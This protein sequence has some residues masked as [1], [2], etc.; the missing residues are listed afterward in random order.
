MP[1]LP[2]VGVE[3]IIPEDF[4]ALKYYGRGPHE[5][6]RDRKGSAILAVHQSSVEMEHFPFIPP[7]ENGGHEDCLWLTL[8]DGSGRGIAVSS[9]KEF[10]FDIHHNSI[11]DYKN[12][13]HEHELIRRK[14]SYLHIDAAHSGIGG[15]MGWSSYLSEDD[16]V[17]PE[18]YYLNLNIRLLT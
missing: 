12:A 3:L 7:S 15:D 4:E 9:D 5:N 16:R 2:R 1:D 11:S 18:S 8:Q 6:Y 10:H 17:K 14:E 13:R